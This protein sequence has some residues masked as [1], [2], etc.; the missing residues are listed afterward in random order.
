MSQW[1]KWLAN[2]DSRS[3]GI[4]IRFFKKA[5]DVSSMTTSDALDVALCYGWIT[6]QAKPSDEKSWLGRLVRRRP[7][8]IW[9][10]ITT[11]RVETLINQGRIKPGGLKQVIQAKGDG[12]WA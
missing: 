4:W 3:E 5:S 10:K 12:R 7:K 9:S 1:D 2:N 11:H 8:S 6:G